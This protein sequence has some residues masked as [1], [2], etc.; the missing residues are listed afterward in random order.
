MCHSAFPFFG[1]TPDDRESVILEPGWIC[2]Y[3]MGL[4]WAESYNMSISYK[5][6]LIERTVKE[7]NRSSESGNTASRAAHANTP[8][9]RQLQGRARDN[10]PAKLRRFT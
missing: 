8:D 3:Y 10:V 2:L 6:W 1:L 5:R 9:V 7:L 4:T